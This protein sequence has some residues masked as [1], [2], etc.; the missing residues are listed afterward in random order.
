MSVISADNIILVGLSGT[1]KT[2]VGQLVARQLRWNPVDTD[3]EIEK[4]AG[5]AV[6]RI[7]A[8]EGEPAFRRMEKQV[9]REV[10]SRNSQ[11]VATGAGAV[12][13]PENLELML[14][15]GLVICLNARPETILSRLM[16]DGS[17]PVQSRPLLSGPDPLGIIREL[18]GQRQKFYSMAH[19]TI[20]T[21]DVFVDA[22][23]REVLKRWDTF[24]G[25]LPPSSEV[26]RPEASKGT[27]GAT[28]VDSGQ[29]GK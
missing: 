16:G 12:V 9:L 5:K 2:H 22:V 20:N 1:G 13:D 26:K 25:A 28:T 8:E 3:S 4:R 10:C 6:Q 11:V 23:A 18:L 7:F 17:V 27:Q 24:A 19:L 29:T 15:R 21:D 14:G